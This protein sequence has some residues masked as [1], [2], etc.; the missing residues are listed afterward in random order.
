[1]NDFLLNPTNTV[2]AQVPGQQRFV[3]RDPNTGA[4]LAQSTAPLPTTKLEEPVYYASTTKSTSFHRKDGKRLVFVGGIYEADILQDVQYFEEEI[5]NENPY[6][7]RANAAEIEAYQMSKDPRKVI[8]EQMVKELVD[9]PEELEALERRIKELR[10]AKLAGNSGTTDEQKLGGTI[11]QVG[12]EAVHFDGGKV[13][14][15][16]K[17]PGNDFQLST[18]GSDK[19]KDAS[20]TSGLAALG[21]LAS[22]AGAGKA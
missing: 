3:H 8:R 9:N 20:G 5:A 12:K 13:V 21:S 14:V 10:A 11:A 6:L 15:N 18:V 17:T 4:I 2:Q 7:R 1:M 22:N 19:I 16:E